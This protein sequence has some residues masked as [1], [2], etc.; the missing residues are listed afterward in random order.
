M[1]ML[2]DDVWCWDDVNCDGDGM[3]GWGVWCGVGCGVGDDDDVGWGGDDVM[4]WMWW[5]VWG[6]GWMWEGCDGDVMCVWCV[7]FWVEVWVFGVVLDGVCVEGDVV[8]CVGGSGRRGRVVVE[9]VGVRRDVAVFDDVL[10]C[11]YDWSVL[12]GVG[13]VVVFVGVLCG[14]GV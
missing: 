11:F 3:W 1:L 13:G 14:V 10:V 6:R 5:D 4:D 8:D 2:C 12:C 7:R 9:I